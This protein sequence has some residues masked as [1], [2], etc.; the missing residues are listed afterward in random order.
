MLRIPPAL[1]LSV[2]Y[3]D[4][5]TRPIA[6]CNDTH[7][8]AAYPLV[9]CRNLQLIIGWW[10]RV[11]LRP[12]ESYTLGVK[13]SKWLWRG[14]R[15]LLTSW[16]ARGILVSAP[17]SAR[18]MRLALL[19]VPWS[20]YYLP[21]P[22]CQGDQ[23]LLRHHGLDMMFPCCY[24][25]HHLGQIEM[26]REE[27]PHSTGS[28]FS[29]PEGIDED[30]TQFFILSCLSLFRGFSILFQPYLSSCFSFICVPLWA[31]STTSVISQYSSLVKPI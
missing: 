23:L 24:H 12:R 14:L 16:I 17:S 31:F 11:T 15:T 5:I 29:H 6:N 20:C 18:M 1:H 10:L 3:I 21:Q 4:D 26:L 7:K 22:I 30:I 25:D 28:S 8:F 19:S 9:F 2:A 13:I 27:S